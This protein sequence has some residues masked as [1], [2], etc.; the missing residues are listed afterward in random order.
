MVTIQAILGSKK[1]GLPNRLRSIHLELVKFFSNNKYR[2]KINPDDIQ[3]F[4]ETDEL[5]S[6]AEE[7]KMDAIVNEA[8]KEGEV[9]SRLIAEIQET[10]QTSISDLAKKL[11]LSVAATYLLLSKG[12]EQ[13]LFNGYITKDKNTYMSNRYVTETVVNLFKNE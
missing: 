12:L 10:H 11:D 4:G 2:S 3:R 5:V 13:K 1:I 8:L 6:Q 9:R 7:G